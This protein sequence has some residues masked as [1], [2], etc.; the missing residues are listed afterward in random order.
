MPNDTPKIHSSFELIHST[1]GECSFSFIKNIFFCRH[2]CVCRVPHSLRT[3]NSLHSFVLL[4]PFNSWLFFWIE[5]EFRINTSLTD[6][7]AI[8]AW[9]L[10]MESEK[11]VQLWI[12]PL[13]QIALHYMHC[14]LCTTM[15]TLI[16]KRKFS[17]LQFPF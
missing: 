8:V 3:A 16:G 2:H 5:I 13:I 11:K 6:T 7:A 17:P 10:K 1:H 4:A 9:Q 12:L 14:A 15:K